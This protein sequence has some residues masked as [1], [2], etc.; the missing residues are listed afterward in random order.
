V[1]AMPKKGFKVCVCGGAQ[2]V[3]QPLSMLLAMDPRVWD[4]TVYDLVSSVTP[5]EGVAADLQCI[6][7]PCQVRAC[8]LD[9]SKRAVDCEQ[10]EAC[11]KDCD[12][13]IACIGLASLCV[14]RLDTNMMLAKGVVEA[15]AKYCPKAV[16]GLVVNPAKS[17]V[18]TVVPAMAK[19]YERAGLDPLKIC[20]VT[21]LDVVRANKLVHMETKAPPEDINV[22]VIGGTDGQTA[23]PLFSQDRAASSLPAARQDELVAEVQAASQEILKKK[24]MKCGATL[25]QAYACARFANA[26]LSGL[27][28]T[29][30]RECCFVKS[31]ACPGLDYFAS[32][33]TFGPNGIETVHALGKL[34]ASEQAHLEEVKKQLEKSIADGLKYAERYELS[35]GDGS[36]PV[37]S[38]G[39]LSPLAR[40]AYGGRSP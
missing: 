12:L 9:S 24:Q 36:S 27:E 28:G 1:P 37:A 18:N 4:L 20:G 10:V 7:R 26:V 22:P 2:Q 29:R 8:T 35:K 32:P 34:S 6:E 17:E 13:V 15:C 3:G 23:L 11:L 19:L 33:V 14:S 31:S 30:T 21:S 16:V 5:P 39:G 38:A 25:T 40:G